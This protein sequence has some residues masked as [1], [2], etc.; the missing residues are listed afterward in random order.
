MPPLTVLRRRYRTADQPASFSGIS[1]VG[2]QFNISPRESRRLLAGVPSY[3]IHREVKRPKYRNPFYVYKIREQVQVD[4]IDVSQMSKANQNI[5][6]LLTGIDMFSKYLVCIPMKSKNARDSRDAMEELVIQF[7]NSY[8]KPKSIMSDAGQEFVCRSVQTYLQSENIKHFVPGSDMK[9]P[10][11]ERVNK[12]IQ[13]KIYQYLSDKKN[14]RY[15]D[16][17]SDLVSSYNNTEHSFI[18]M[19]PND[20]ERPENFLWVR[21]CHMRKYRD[22]LSKTQKKKFKVGDVVRIAAWKTKFHRSYKPQQT[23][24]IFEITKVNTSMPIPRYYLKSLETLD[25]IDGAFHANE[26]TLVDSHLHD[27]EKVL[28]KRTRNGRREVLV[29]W[30]GYNEI[31]N[32]WEPAEEIREA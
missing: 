9:C 2:R 23:M 30:Q 8:A 31:Y 18:E 14:Q 11:V 27:V 7:E 28:K 15:I 21:D 17:L 16:A 24:E 29:K 4:L 12:T 22:I 25:D 19:T 13:R 20:A 10:G 1:K 32:S 26:L 5:T 6:F 3:T